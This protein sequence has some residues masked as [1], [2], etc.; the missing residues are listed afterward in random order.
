MEWLDI[1]IKL[2]IN[3]KGPFNLYVINHC[4]KSCL[5]TPLTL[6]TLTPVVLKNLPIAKPPSPIN[7]MAPPINATAPS[8]KAIA[9]VNYSRDLVTLV[10][11]YT[12]E[13]KYSRKDNNFDRKFTIF[14]NL[15]NRVGI[16]QKAKIKGFP[17]MLYSIA[18]NFYYK[19]K[20]TYTTF[21]DIYNAIYNY[22]KGPEYKRG[23]LTKWNAI[24]LKT[25]IIKSEGKSTEDCL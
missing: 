25:V 22:F 24:T 4:L 21:N 3:N 23:V 17:M 18:I 2:F 6:S 20:A 5:L 8:I 7:V 11:I 12:E 13:S 16:P 10:K 1:E 9:A 15:Y 14:N 19:N